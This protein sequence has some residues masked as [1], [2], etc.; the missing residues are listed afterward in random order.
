MA[1]A[2]LIAWLVTAVLG[3]TMLGIWIARG[4]LRPAAQPRRLHARRVRGHDGRPGPAHRT[5]RRRFLNQA[6]PISTTRAGD[7]LGGVVAAPWE[8]LASLV[9]SV[10]RALYDYVRRQDHPVTR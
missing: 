5:G 2:A 3:F 6:P 1:I 10:R 7:N 4:A 9:D 8:A